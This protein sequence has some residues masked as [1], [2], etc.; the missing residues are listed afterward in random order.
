MNMRMRK[1]PPS[2]ATHTGIVAIMR[3]AMP[4][5]MVCSPQ[6]TSPIPP[7]RSSAP[8]IAES[9]HSRRVGQMKSPRARASDQPNRIAPAR[10]N[11]IDAITNG[12][13]VVTAMAMP[14]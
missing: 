12:G 8:T 11:R 7:P 14:R 6:A 2:T 9:R 10:R 13:K 1:M 3:A 5:G 4:D